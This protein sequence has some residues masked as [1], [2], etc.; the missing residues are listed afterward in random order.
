MQAILDRRSRTASGR[1]RLRV[2]FTEIGRWTN[3]RKLNAFVIND[4]S[5]GLSN[6]VLGLDQV[7][8]SILTPSE[9]K[10]TRMGVTDWSQDHALND[11][12]NVQSDSNIEITLHGTGIWTVYMNSVQKSCMVPAVCRP[13]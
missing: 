8:T 4:G 2:S 9:P 6:V 11:S 3:R 10:R 12:V 5:T 13:R 7:N 1:E